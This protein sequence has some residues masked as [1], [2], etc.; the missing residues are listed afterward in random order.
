[1]MERF[2]SNL[3]GYTLPVWCQEFWEGGL[4]SY[5]ALQ[6]QWHG[7]ERTLMDS[8]TSFFE[9]GRVMTNCYLLHNPRLERAATSPW[10]YRVVFM[11]EYAAY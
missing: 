4:H 3:E 1:M 2:E 8:M 7:D 9:E 6:L 5:V 10:T 11:E